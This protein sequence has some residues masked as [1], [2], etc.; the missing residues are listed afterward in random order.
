[1]R[2]LSLGRAAFLFSE[3]ALSMNAYFSDRL[4]NQEQ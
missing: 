1:M 2:R 3:Y 4:Y